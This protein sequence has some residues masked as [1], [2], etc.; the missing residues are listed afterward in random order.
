MSAD[1]KYH[2]VLHGNVSIG[3]PEPGR[4]HNP[5]DGAKLYFNGAPLNSDPQ[6]IGRHDDS[7][8][9]STLRISMGDNS[10]TNA[11]KVEIGYQ[12][13]GDNKWYA[14]LTVHSNG[15]VEVN[16]TLKANKIE[17]DH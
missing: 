6:W 15:V 4:A 13:A 10:N 3:E 1:I 14:V 16:G 17:S 2:T 8:D 5:E 12:F 7:N 11:D 9:R